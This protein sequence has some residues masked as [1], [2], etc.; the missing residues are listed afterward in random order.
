[1]SSKDL[2]KAPG[3]FSAPNYP[4]GKAGCILSHKDQCHFLEYLAY[5]IT[6]AMFLYDLANDRHIWT[7]GYYKAILGYEPEEVLTLGIAEAAEML[8]PDDLVIARNG[9]EALKSG[10]TPVCSGIYRVRHKEGHW[11]YLYCTARM[12]QVDPDGPPSH[13][14][15]LAID[16]TGH[17]HTDKHLA[18]LIAHSRSEQNQLL[19]NTLT[20]REKEVIRHL[21]A[22]YSC[23]EIAAELGI[24][25]Y[26]VETHVKNIHRKLGLNHLSSLVSFAIESG[27]TA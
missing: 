16:F 15:G 5:N 25:F 12:V 23:K 14:L 20:K 8:H 27:L 7:N 24:T 6:A 9:L 2:H 13:V 21:V 1:M 17:I 26:T 10:I 22:G 4:D 18:E 3:F 11:I 19:L